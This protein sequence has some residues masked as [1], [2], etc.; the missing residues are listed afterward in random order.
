VDVKLILKL[1]DQILCKERI[2]AFVVAI[3][4]IVF[5]LPRSYRLGFDQLSIYLSKLFF[6]PMLP[7]G[8]HPIRCFCAAQIVAA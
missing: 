8:F 3:D 1:V 2:G 5:G 4:C 6:G 7:E